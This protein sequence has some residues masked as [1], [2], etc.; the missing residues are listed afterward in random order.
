MTIGNAPTALPILELKNVRVHYGATCIL[1]IPELSVIEGDILLLKGPNGSGKS[2]LLNGL[3]GIGATLLGH[4]EY[5]SNSL[6]ALPAHSRARCGLRLLPQG[7]HIFP[8]LTPIEHVR[9]AT[10]VLAHSKDKALQK[11]LLFLRSG[12]ADRAAVGVSGG[13][14]KVVLLASLMAPGLRLLMLDEPFAGLDMQ[15]TA[16]VFSLIQEAASLGS[17]MIIA[18]HTQLADKEFPGHKKT[19]SIVSDAIGYMIDTAHT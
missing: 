11:S 19:V 17:A 9:L 2:S 13:E 16:H 7:R 15:A 12:T 1:R 6:V 4:I 18:D 5:L 10:Q 3:S 14:A 8:R